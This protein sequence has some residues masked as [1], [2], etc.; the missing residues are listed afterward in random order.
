VAALSSEE[1]LDEGRRVI[2][3]LFREKVSAV[4]R[5]SVRMRSPLPPDSRGPRPF[6]RKE[7]SGPPWANRS[8]IGHSI[9]L[10]ASLST[11][12]C[13]TSIVIFPAPA[14]TGVH[15]QTGT[16]GSSIPRPLCRRSHRGC[17]SRN[18]PVRGRHARTH[19]QE[20]INEGRD[21]F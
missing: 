7:S 20:L 21:V 5:L 10:P 11:L 19:G 3:I 9:R 14:R 12:S 8:N 1:L 18:Y 15:R 13:S 17:R 6:R 4:H 16:L 2:W